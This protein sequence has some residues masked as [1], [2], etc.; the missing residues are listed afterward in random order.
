MFLQQRAQALSTIGVALGSGIK[1]RNAKKP[2][3]AETEAKIVALSAGLE[4][5]DTNRA[6]LLEVNWSASSCANQSR[7]SLLCIA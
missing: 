7:T 2:A 6:T 1:N 5:F 3:L 4:A